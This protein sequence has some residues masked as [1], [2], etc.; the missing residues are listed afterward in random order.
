M[1][2]KYTITLFSDA[3]PG[4]GLGGEMVN[5]FVPR[6]VNNQPYIPASHIKGLMRE[7][8]VH[9]FDCLNM[10]KAF[11]GQVFGTRYYKVLDT[12]DGSVKTSAV[13]CGPFKG[14][15]LFRISDALLKQEDNKQ[16]DGTER[17]DTEK[18]KTLFVSRTA[19]DKSGVAKE[20]SLR[21]N[22]AIAVGTVFHG[23]L[24]VDAPKDSAA[25]L[26][27]RIGLLSITALGGSRN[28]GCGRCQ[29]SLDSDADIAGLIPKLIDQL[30]TS[31]GDISNQSVQSPKTLPDFSGKSVSLELV[32]RASAPVCVPENAWVGK[33]NIVSSGFSIP[34]SAV[35]GA[36]IRLF[37]DYEAGTMDRLYECEML[38]ASP[39]QPCGYIDKNG[40]TSKAPVSIRVSLTHK[41]AKFSLKEYESTDFEDEALIPPYKIEEVPDRAPMK[42]SD[43]VLL[44][45]SEGEIALW[46]GSDMPHIIQMHGV[47]RNYEG[48][49][50]RNLFTVDS[51]AELIWRGWAQ[52]PKE[53]AGLLIQTSI[54]VAFGTRRSV[55]GQGILQIEKTKDDIPQEWKAAN[56]ADKTVFVVQS[57]ISVQIGKYA[58]DVKDESSETENETPTPTMVSVKKELKSAGLSD[59]TSAGGAP[60]MDSIEKVFKGMVKEWLEKHEIYDKKIHTWASTG[61]LFGWNGKNGGRQSGS[62]VILPGSVIQL[63][64]ALTED[65]IKRLLGSGFDLTKDDFK[66]GYG[67]LCVHPGK[68]CKKFSG[69]KT[70]PVFSGNSDRAKWVEQMIPLANTP[71]PS[72][73]QISALREELRNNGAQKA[74]DY[75]K[76]QLK[77]ANVSDAWSSCSAVVQEMLEAIGSN[78]TRQ[79]SAIQVLELLT[80]L[81]IVKAGKIS[82]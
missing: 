60:T 7:R 79:E 24:T 75:F 44:V 48:E 14:E 68:A 80:D 49:S 53:I 35:R 46:K 50:E 28:R 37:R 64:E 70:S 62:A 10:E 18:S 38:Q 45:D 20:S 82:K 3:Q 9:M 30:K 25:D 4:T 5:D 2:Y 69:N 8:S 13:K 1:N 47:H 71:L 54:P 19:L 76:K 57:P 34:A 43:G 65:Q 42:A 63:T 73:S 72:P 26:M 6:D 40:D 16:K 32:F 52:V 81:A 11:I 15:S 33:N 41:A 22:E 29:V 12:N 59:Q 67:I 27:V 61:Y 51:M 36:L 23:E 56:M 55:Q 74:L 21:T 66:R 39:L 58:S 77:R 17:G 78:K 31:N